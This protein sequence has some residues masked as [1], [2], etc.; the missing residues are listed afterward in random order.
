MKR[1]VLLL[2]ALPG[3][4]GAVELHI[5]FGALERMLTEQVFSQEGRRYVRGSKTNKCNF[6]YLE[7]PQVR[8]EGGRLRMK[9]RF[10]GRSALNVVGQCVG[11]GDAF[12]VVITAVPMYRNGAISLQEVKVT[13]EGKSGYYIRRVCEAMQ[14]SLAKDFQYALEAEA[15]KMLEGAGGTPGYKREVRKFSAPEIR[16]T[17]EALVLQ[18][19]FELTVK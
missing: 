18:V 16:V 6:A 1:F 13:S 10:T 3:C 11:L 19:D 7:K 2:M 5:Q 9:A 15:R 14:A 4:A 8:G 17:N 12:D